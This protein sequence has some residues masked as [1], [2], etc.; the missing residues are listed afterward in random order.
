MPRARAIPSL[1]ERPAPPIPAQITH[2]H[3]DSIVVVEDDSD[4]ANL[5]HYN[6]EAAGYEVECIANGSCALMRIEAAPPALVVVDWGIPTLSGLELVRQL[7]RREHT[8]GLPVVMLT[9]RS[10]NDERALAL[11]TGVDVFLGKPFSLAE[12][13]A[14]VAD[15]LHRHG[16]GP[17]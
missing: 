2:G 6:F 14:A 17:V 4:L 9:G 7:R 16:G 8:K 3:Q 15:L 5:L 13:M 11:A 1:Y 10:G 12:L